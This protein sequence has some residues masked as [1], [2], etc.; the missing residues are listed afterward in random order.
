MYD[1]QNI[2]EAA[3]HTMSLSEYFKD[4]LGIPEEWF[5]NATNTTIVGQ[6]LVDSVIRLMYPFKRYGTTAGIGGVD[7]TM[8]NAG[9]G[10]L[11]GIGVIKDDI[12]G[13]I[14]SHFS[15]ASK[16]V[17]VSNLRAMQGPG[18][19]DFSISDF[20]DLI[21]DFSGQAADTQIGAA[22]YV[23]GSDMMSYGA[24]KSGAVDLPGGIEKTASAEK[25]LEGI[26]GISAEF[27]K[28]NIA[29]IDPNINKDSLLRKLMPKDLD[30]SPLSVRS[31]IS[32]FQYSSQRLP[33]GRYPLRT[34]KSYYI[35]EV[36]TSELSEVKERWAEISTSCESIVSQITNTARQL[37]CPDLGET[38]SIHF[39]GYPGTNKPRL[40]ASGLSYHVLQ[41]G[42]AALNTSAINI[43][44]G[45]F[46]EAIRVE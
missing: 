22:L 1:N 16:I 27:T 31:K 6:L 23:I 5:K 37:K 11:L 39:S 20:R 40:I 2:A 38:A 4:R 46:K 32:T 12:V 30:A 15:K 24:F 25:I 43:S 33:S 45:D 7:D 28:K 13:P 29:D 42:S 18:T 34:G 26:L 14:R 41:R 19:E 21:N 9:P 3:A 10:D 44:S 35:D 36:L 8:R 17:N